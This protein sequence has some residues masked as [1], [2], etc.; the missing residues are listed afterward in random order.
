MSEAS[1][2]LFSNQLQ[3]TGIVN[4]TF[5]PGQEHELAA[6]LLTAARQVGAS[7][8]RIVVNFERAGTGRLTCLIDGATA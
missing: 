3:E 1:I 6:Q 8:V 5:L 4:T 2:D 7:T